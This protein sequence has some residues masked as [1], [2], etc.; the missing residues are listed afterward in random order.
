MASSS[1]KDNGMT[2]ATHD[3]ESG[4]SKNNLAFSAEIS[5][6]EK[7]EIFERIDDII[8][9]SRKA[10]SSMTTETGDGITGT[11]ADPK[12]GFKSKKSG[13]LFPILVNFLTVMMLAGGFLLLYLFQAEADMQSRGGTRVFT[14]VERTLIE[15]IRRETNALLAAKDL[16]IAIILSSLAY[17][18]MQLQELMAGGGERTQEQLNLQAY[19][20]ARYEERQTALTEAREDRVRI[21]YEARLRETTIR[22]QVDAR[23]RGLDNAAGGGRVLHDS[24]LEAAREEL[25]RLSMEQDLAMRMESQIAGLFATVQRQIAEGSFDGAAVTIE[26]LQ[27]VL[28]DSDF[29]G[30]PG[31]QTRREFY[32]LTTRTL[33][34]LIASASVAMN[35][36]AGDIIAQV[37][38]SAQIIAQLESSVAA[39]Q[40]ANVALSQEIGERDYTIRELQ[41]QNALHEQSIAILNTQLAQVRMVLQTLTQ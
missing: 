1:E 34:T 25:A 11:D 39:L 26:G 16:E 27:L 38:D 15:E 36:M 29:Q 5:E 28:G 41:E 14:D 35:G 40:S 3:N 8:E 20:R 32:A 12:K 9:K 18:E 10:P 30:L 6:D 19:F 33:E 21:L 2:A 4:D 13:R 17:I 7:R 22:A 37:A 31:M 24:D 23:A